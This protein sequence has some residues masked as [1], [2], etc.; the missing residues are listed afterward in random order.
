MKLPWPCAG[1]DVFFSDPEQVN[2]SHLMRGERFTHNW[3]D[4]TGYEYDVA[5]D[6]DL[7]S[8]PKI[9]DK[10]KVLIINGHSEYWS[11][12]AYEGVDR[13]LRNGGNAIET[14]CSGE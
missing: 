7:H 1:P 8:N 9:L 11:I 2:Y 13:F 14:Q 3:L 4:E 12:E 6:H 5:T 10:Y